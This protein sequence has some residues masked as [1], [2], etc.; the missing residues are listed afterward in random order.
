MN[1]NQDN[2]QQPPQQRNGF[3]SYL[4]AVHPAL[5]SNR[6]L[7]LPP[8]LHRLPDFELEYLKKAH[9]HAQAQ[10]A[11]I[12]YG[13]EQQQ[14]QQ[15]H[16]LA[17]R[18]S[19]IEH[20]LAAAKFANVYESHSLTASQHNTLPSPSMVM[21][22][23]RRPS[24]PRGA[25]HPMNMHLSAMAH[26]QIQFQ[27]Q[28]QQK[29]SAAAAGPTVINTNTNNAINLPP[30][31]H[32]S[33]YFR[34]PA[35]PAS[36]GL[37]TTPGA[38]GPPPPP[39]T[40]APT[41]NS[42]ALCN[43]NSNALQTSTS[44]T[45]SQNPLNHLQNM[46]PFDFRK[47]NSAALGAFPGLPPPGAARLSPN[48][49]AHHQHLQQQAAQQ[50]AMLAQARRRINE[51]TTPSEKSA[52]AAAAAAAAAQSNQFFNAMAM[53]GHPLP[54][55][56]PPPPPLPHVH[57]PPPPST[58]ANATSP[59]SSLPSGLTSNQVAA[60]A[61]AA[62]ASGNPMPHSFLASHFSGINN[63]LTLGKSAL[64]AKTPEHDKSKTSEVDNLRETSTSRLTPPTRST[65]Q[66]SLH[67]ASTNQQQSSSSN[68]VNSTSNNYQSSRNLRESSHPPRS[69]LQHDSSPGAQTQRLS[70]L[71]TSGGGMRPGRKNHSPG[72]RQWGSIPANLGTQFINPVT[73]KKRVQCNVCL[74]TFCDKG[75]LK[76]H[77]SAVHLREMHKCTVDG[78]NMMFSSRRSRNRHS[79]NPNP[80]LH[81]PHLRRKISPHDGRSAQPHPILLQ[82]PNGLMP[83]LNPFGTFPMLTPPPD[84]RH[85]SMGTLG[86]PK[87]SQ[88]FMHRA[89]MESSIMGR[90]ESRHISGSEGM[91][92]EDEDEEGLDG[93]I[94]IGDIDDDDDDDEGEGIVVVGDEGDSMLDKT[95]SEDFNVEDHVIEETNSTLED[96]SRDNLDRRSNSKTP[97]HHNHKAKDQFSSTMDNAKQDEDEDGRSTTGK[98]STES[99]DDTLSVAD[100]CDVREEYDTSSTS[101]VVNITSNS[102]TM[103]SGSSSSKRKRK[104]QN[105]VRCA[106]QSNEASCDNSV[107]SEMAADLSL[108]TR[109]REN[110]EK[111]N[112]STLDLRKRC[113]YP[114]EPA[115]EESQP[116]TNATEAE[117]AKVLPSPPL[118]PSTSAS[119]TV[120][121]STIPSAPVKMEPK[122]NLEAERS[123]KA[124]NEKEKFLDLSSNQKS[125]LVVG[126]ETEQQEQQQQQQN[127]KETLLMPT[128]KQEPKDDLLLDNSIQVAQSTCNTEDIEQEENRYLRIKKEILED[129]FR[130]N[131]ST[132]EDYENANNNNNNILPENLTVKSS[133]AET[134]ESRKL[135]TSELE[136]HNGVE[137]TNDEGEVPID[138]ENPLRCTACG[139]VF[140]NH[141]HLKTHYQCEHLK[142]HHK[143]NID[144][145]N[146]A[147]PSK[148]SRD[149]HSSNLNLHRKLL[150]TGDNHTVDHLPEPIGVMGGKSFVNSSPGSITSTLQ[151]EF[152]ARL[153]AG[154]AHGLP[155]LN[156]EALKHFP[157]ANATLTGFPDA[158]STFLND[159][160]FMLQQPG[161]PLI[162][163]GLPGLAAFP[164][165]SPHLLNAAQFN[166]LNPFCR[167]PSSD[168]HSPHSATPPIGAPRSPLMIGNKVAASTIYTHQEPDQRNTSS[169]PSSSMGTNEGTT[170]PLYGGSTNSSSSVHNTTH[171]PDRIS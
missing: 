98:H 152:L 102:A 62:A 124:N 86:E 116:E 128:I 110:Q 20:E 143:C 121:Q 41:S 96:S 59:S 69:S 71:T 105:P 2:S 77:F 169:S 144:G 84:M 13:Y 135:P 19:H 123:N 153:Y 72:K 46:Q 119:E 27:T 149:R 164:H 16:Q 85:H 53:S 78:C 63:A 64:R 15:Q 141:F 56:L 82:T 104:S 24:P 73:G 30:P 44:T 160:R 3:Q 127:G 113:R 42:S 26:A 10:A 138:K 163:P 66:T 51:A 34:N 9:A 171:I 36:C 40:S 137:F 80:K 109:E 81:S 106:V 146:A 93:G 159:P 88:D 147:F 131:I 134:V 12:A 140:Q 148:R 55:H 70:R 68:C 125:E 108:R 60:I 58:M 7:S 47:I 139:D 35:S 17:R 100:S 76:I 87:H 132:E 39:L 45:Q 8:P 151:A 118:T 61:A 25:A 79:A 52:A 22:P 95:N 142:L 156:F 28:L 167:R 75:A 158:A 29:L 18:R 57:P 112:S 32:L 5:H 130:L 162:F 129:S 21:S 155:P 133:S 154:A 145:C 23:S 103:P 49:L 54:F 83:G 168:S 107:D 99:N 157:P 126:T 65:S 31:G 170:H 161:N 43:T 11:A 120:K 74:K 33:N 14:V 50:A 89:Y 111:E 48:D 101:L 117:Q 1:I 122:E 150:S 90:Y 37:A 4:P 166:G 165:L 114:E 91:I 38:S 92:E 67:G 6:N 94:H 136:E 97:T 115:K